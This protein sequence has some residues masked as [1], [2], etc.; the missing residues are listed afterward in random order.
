M[1]V[2]RPYHAT[3]FNLLLGYL[4]RK[5]YVNDPQTIEHIRDNIINDIGA[6]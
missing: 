1:L 3:Q 6:N 2:D 4:M 5:V